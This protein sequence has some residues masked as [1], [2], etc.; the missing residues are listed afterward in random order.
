[1]TIFFYKVCEPYGCFSNFS[2]HSIN[3]DGSHWPT[4]EHYYQAQKFVGTSFQYLCQKIKIAPTPE[5]ATVIG[6]NSSYR[7]R[8][9]WELAKKEVM[10]L[11]VLTKFL[12][13]PDLKRLLVATDHHVIVENSPT[14]CYWGCGPDGMGQNQ[15]GQILMRVRQELRE[16]QEISE[17]SSHTPQ[18]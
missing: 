13:Y 4:S 9:D 8:E 6:R 2:P 7:V 3:V 12:I 5:A 16:S 17:S 18:V 14:D 11:A 10:Y 15:L 1:M